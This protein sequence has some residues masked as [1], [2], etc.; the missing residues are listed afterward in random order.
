M[1]KPPFDNDV[2]DETTSPLYVLLNP[3]Y[4]IFCQSTDVGCPS[5]EHGR[6]NCSTKPP[7]YERFLTQEYKDALR[8]A[9]TQA[10]TQATIDLHL[11]PVQETFFKELSRLLNSPKFSD[12]VFASVLFKELPNGILP[13]LKFMCNDRC[14]KCLY[15]ASKTKTGNP[16]PP[17][18]PDL[19]LINGRY[20]GHVPFYLKNLSE[21][22][23]NMIARI[24]PVIKLI[25]SG[26]KFHTQKGEMYTIV[27][28]IFEI[29]KN[30]PALPSLHD[31]A[32]LRHKRT[33]GKPYFFKL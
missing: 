26:G 9:V 7:P 15:P 13:T 28:N 23:K 2:Y 22:E 27:N 10:T 19:A 32:I 18:L 31:T 24:N 12:H 29:R 14:Y 5:I 20:I 1:C 16:P 17:K 8:N 33:D 30:L 4:D 21:I 11:L 3:I 6:Y 25:L